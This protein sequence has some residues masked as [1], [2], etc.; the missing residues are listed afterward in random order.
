MI[1]LG[2]TDDLQTAGQSFSAIYCEDLQNLDAKLI[3]RLSKFTARIRL[4]SSFHTRAFGSNMAI[5]MVAQE[6]LEPSSPRLLISRYLSLHKYLD[7]CA[8][9]KDT[10]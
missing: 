6:R 10:S 4:Y 7:Q 8:N 9:A 1:M 3:Q 5:D 2:S